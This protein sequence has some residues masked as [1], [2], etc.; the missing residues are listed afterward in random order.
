[1][2]IYLEWKIVLGQRIVISG[3][4]TVGREEGDRK[5]HR[6]TKRRTS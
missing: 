6:K 4:R 3:H 2:D 5:N 1:M